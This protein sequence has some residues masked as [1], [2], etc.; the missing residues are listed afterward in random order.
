MSAQQTFWRL[1]GNYSIEIPKVQRDYA[2]GRED[3][4]TAQIRQNFV[5]T[6]VE[7]VSDPDKSTDLDFIYGS[8]RDDTLILLDG[9]Q[10]LTTLFLLHWYLALSAEKLPEASDKLSRFRYETRVGAR[11]FMQALLHNGETIKPNT[12]PGKISDAIMDA[13]WFFSIWKT[14]PTVQSMLVMLDEIHQQFK[15]QDL[16]MPKLWAQLICHDKPPVT[17]HFL[18]MDEFAL[19][20]ELYIKMNA[21]GRSLSHFENFKAWLQSQTGELDINKKERFFS[22]LDKEWADVFWQQRERGV[23][24]TDNYMLRFFK[25]VVIFRLGSLVS[26]KGEKLNAKDTSLLSTLLSSVEMP[27]QSLGEYRI[28]DAQTFEGISVF[29][30]FIHS[31]GSCEPDEHAKSLIDVFVRILRSSDYLDLTRFF[32]L[33]SGVNN[34]FSVASNP[35]TSSEKLGCW[36]HIIERL[37]NNTYIDSQPNLLRAARAIQEFKILGTID[38][39]SELAKQD[40]KFID[41]FSERQR[42]EEILKARLICEDRAWLDLLRTYENHSYFYGQ[43]GFLLEY[44]RLK[45]AGE[46]CQ[47]TF[48]AVAVKAAVLFSDDLIETHDFL[49]QRALLSIG[50][51][52]VA[53]G[54]NY[55][56]CRPTKSNARERNENWRAVFNDSKRAPYLF[57][58]LDKLSVGLEKEGLQKV[59]ERAQTKDWRQLFIQFPETIG[60]CGKREARFDYYDVDEIYLLHGIRMSGRHKGLVSS[61]LYLDINSSKDRDLEPLK[62]V[63]DN[64]V[65]SGDDHYTG[66]TFSPFQGGTLIVDYEDNFQIS[67]R[68]EN[69]LELV[70]TEDDSIKALH[71]AIQR[72]IEMAG[73]EPYCNQQDVVEEAMEAE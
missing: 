32:A 23:F 58:L 41:F 12:I 22:K 37:I 55:N 51:Y 40:A 29:L 17:F 26:I 30:D 59:I 42:R 45:N 15:S 11:E 10:R 34:A 27:L 68:D 8:V 44:T 53:S 35:G 9:Q 64:K 31:R 19:T 20:D 28:F 4:K 72:I 3:S 49:L 25:A 57:D 67:L 16:N 13:H 65:V 50:D 61:C 73:M 70:L 21:R 1:L 43:V 52:L 38:V 66:L 54:A 24:E 2:Q 56:F 6:L 71:R 36:F 46:Y 47:K 39:Y 48:S 5:S 7:L 33:Y 18:N 14:D 63:M 62:S 69:D 60:Y